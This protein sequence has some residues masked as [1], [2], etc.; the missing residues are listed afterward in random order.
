MAVAY[1]MALNTFHIDT[2]EAMPIELTSWGDS[3][4]RYKAGLL[5]LVIRRG[6]GAERHLY[7]RQAK[8]FMKLLGAPACFRPRKA[9]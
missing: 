8:Q 9:A 5:H 4:R 3:V 2:Y 6:D 1:P 7:G